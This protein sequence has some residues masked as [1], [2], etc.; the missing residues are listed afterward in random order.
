M[1][2]TCHDEYEITDSEAIRKFSYIKGGQKE[3]RIRK[4][5][6]D[7][8]RTIKASDDKDL[9]GYYQSL[10]KAYD[11]GKWK[12][13][14]ANEGYLEGVARGIVYEYSAG[15]MSYPDPLDKPSR[16]IVTAEI[17]RSASRM[18][19]V[20][21]FE[22]GRFRRLMPIELERLNMFPDDWTKI[23][24]ISDSRRG[25]LMGNALVV[26]IVGGLS[27]PLANLIRHR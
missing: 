23:D 11:S 22:E 13:S 1:V 20:I 19:H 25:F 6:C 14:R 5:D 26:G 16:T 2:G 7:M 24:G 8:A 10:T 17:G 9:W 18:R 4:A 3:W 12:G 27:G 21:E 15:A